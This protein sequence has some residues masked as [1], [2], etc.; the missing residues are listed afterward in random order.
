M[1]EE[2]EKEVESA[3]T[4]TTG[5]SAEDTNKHRPSLLSFIGLQVNQ[6]S[7]V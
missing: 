2:M 3:E 7:T 6:Q 1:A 5:G 4:T